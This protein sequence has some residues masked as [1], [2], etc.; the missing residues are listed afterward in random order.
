[1]LTAILNSVYSKLVIIMWRRSNRRRKVK[2]VKAV[3][4]LLRDEV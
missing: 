4:G 2:G 3:A 1:M